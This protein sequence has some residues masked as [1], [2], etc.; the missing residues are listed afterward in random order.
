MITRATCRL[1]AFV[2]TVSAIHVAADDTQILK[3][4]SAFSRVTDQRARS[5]ALFTE[6]AKVIRSPRC[7]NCHPATR[8]VTQGDDLHAHVPS[9][10][11]GRFGVGPPGLPCRACHE[12]ANTS[13]LSE[14]IAS[15]PGSPAW[16]IAPASMA[17]QGKTL[18]EICLQIQDPARNGGR[19][20]A[21][22]HE[23]MA[24][25]PV[26]AWAWQPGEGRVPAPGSQ[27]EFAALIGAWIDTGAQCPQS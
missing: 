22:L 23:H 10:D 3:P 7:L 17:W 5:V 12:A 18:R 4:V 26:V 27:A 9:V 24:M 16:G 8:V 1:A 25:D 15:I 14:S 2:V 19:T 20:L 21:K 11:A 13:T 6:A